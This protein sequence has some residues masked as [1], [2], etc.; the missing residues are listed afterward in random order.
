VQE[1]FIF[2]DPHTCRNKKKKKNIRFDP[3]R[4][5]S[6]ILPNKEKKEKQKKKL[7]PSPMNK[8]LFWKKKE[9]KKL[10]P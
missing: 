6:L 3:K 7:K 9:M 2:Y 4:Y 8:K 10:R 1:V 5:S